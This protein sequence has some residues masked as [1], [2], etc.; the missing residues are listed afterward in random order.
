MRIQKALIAN[1]FIPTPLRSGVSGGTASGKTT[2]CEQIIQQLRDHRVVLINQVRGGQGGGGGM[3]PPTY[4]S[5]V[6]SRVSAAT[7]F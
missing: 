3:K 1:P 6:L 7:P 5:K 4:T 2:V